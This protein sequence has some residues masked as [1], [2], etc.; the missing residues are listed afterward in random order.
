[1]KFLF[2][3]FLFFTL[4]TVSAQ[5]NYLLVG[6]YDSPA[7]EGIYV[8]KFDSEQGTAQEISHVKT[9]NPSFLTISKDERFVYAVSETSAK[10]EKPGQVAAFSFDKTTGKL[11][12]LNQQS[13]GGDHPCHV[14]LDNTG[15]WLFVSNYTSGS[16]SCLFVKDNGMLGEGTVVQHSGSG[17]NVERQASAHAHGAII[18]PDNKKLYVT[19]L[20]IDKLMLYNFDEKTGRLSPSQPA[21]MPVVAG[22][23][24]RL[25]TYHPS[26]KTA[27]VIEELSGTIQVFRTKNAGL[28]AIQR[29]STMPQGDEQFAGS[30][31]IHVSSDGKFLYASNRGE[32]N[33]IAIFKVRKNGKLRLIAHQSTLGKSPR[34]FT[35]DPSGKFLL[36]GNQNSDEIVVFKRDVLTGLLSD[37]GQR[38]SIGKP[39]C[40]KWMSVER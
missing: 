25:F 35:I 37:T 20:G 39:V 6:T 15:N 16:V 30:A 22:A 3:T 23:G 31:D 12:L 27:Y 26:K 29:I 11:N 21:F 40:L 13:S 28:M 32:S 5:E 33:T 10:D 8:F 19:D 18:S 24:P 17:S 38:I 14:E 34:N 4:A 2:V 9:P 7:S 36:V 1:M